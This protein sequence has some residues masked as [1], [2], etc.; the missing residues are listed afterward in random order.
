MLL[1]KVSMDQSATTT[2]EPIAFT[3]TVGLSDG[4]CP[5]KTGRDCRNPKVTDNKC[6]VPATVPETTTGSGTHVVYDYSGCGNHPVRWITFD[7]VHDDYP[8]DKNQSA[9]W[10]P[11]QTWSFINQ[12]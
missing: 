4:T 11:A 9:T 3:G 10:M 6:T 7:G 12:S 5:P 8:K 2:L 1:I